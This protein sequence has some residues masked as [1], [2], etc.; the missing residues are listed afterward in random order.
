MEKESNTE[1][2]PNFIV[3]AKFKDFFSIFK[4]FLPF[5]IYF[6]VVWLDNNYAS[7]EKVNELAMQTVAN[8]QKVERLRG[9][10]YYEIQLIDAKLQ[11]I[12]DN[13]QEVKKIIEIH[14]QNK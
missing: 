12:T 4:Y 14:Y 6:I 2:K 10:V 5:F 8:E 3:A 11:N 13:L 7:S 9:D 1:Q